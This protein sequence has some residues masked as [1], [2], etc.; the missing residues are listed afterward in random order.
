MKQHD[1]LS[2]PGEFCRVIGTTPKNR[3]LEFLLASRGIDFGIGD[4]A[5]ETTVNRITT[6]LI[7]NKLIDEKMVKK[8]RVVGRTQLYMINPEN[9][10]VQKLMAVFNTI[11]KTKLP[12]I[13]TT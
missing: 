7:M 8:T 2:E 6:Y 3:I 12:Q 11:L 1:Y 10:R 4:I 5:R 13:I 9:E